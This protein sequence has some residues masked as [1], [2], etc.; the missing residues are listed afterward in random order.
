VDVVVVVVV[1]GAV[2][3]VDAVEVVLAAPSF[4]QTL[5]SP[6][7]GS[8][9]VALSQAAEPVND[10]TTEAVV[11]PYLTFCVPLNV[12]VPYS[13]AHCVQVAVV[14]VG[15]VVA[16]VVVGD[17]DV[18]DVVV[19]VGDVVVLVA[20][21]FQQILFSPGAGSPKV[22][23]LQAAEPVNDFTTEAVVVPYLTFCVPLNVQVPY[24]TAHWVQLVLVVEVV[25]VVVVVGVVVVLRTRSMVESVSLADTLST[26]LVP[27]LVPVLPP[28]QAASTAA[29]RRA[30]VIERGEEDR[31]K[32]VISFLAIEPSGSGPRPGSISAKQARKPTESV[33]RKRYESRWC[34]PET[35]D[36][37]SV[38]AGFERGG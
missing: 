24:S 8:P 30:T 23:L 19:V 33:R 29:D 1:A 16:V 21:L 17:V 31:W 37:K 26:A 11:V 6:G 10:F 14:V 12:Q 27:V 20:P 28:P 13:K 36:N 15:D 22:A 3:V 35:P 2:T 32:N 4:Q 34:T 38:R 7:A 5:F 18:V 25:V 9:K